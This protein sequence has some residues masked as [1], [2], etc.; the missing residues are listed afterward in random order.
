MTLRERMK[1]LGVAL[2]FPRKAVERNLFDGRVISSV[3]LNVLCFTPIIIWLAVV[4]INPLYL[5]VLQKY[6][7]VYIFAAI[8]AAILQNWLFPWILFRRICP[9]AQKRLTKKERREI[10][11]FPK[12]TMTVCRQMVLFSV[13]VGVIMNQPIT[14]VNYMVSVPDNFITVSIGLSFVIGIVWQY[15][16]FHSLYRKNIGGTIRNF[17]IFMGFCIVAACIMFII[18][19]VIFGII[20]M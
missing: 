18:L 8:Y 19:I 2:L 17:L 13:L 14:L 11:A 1:M 15:K 4:L 20:I 3:W 9:P 6:Y 16:A 10:E 12:I 7:W 5:S